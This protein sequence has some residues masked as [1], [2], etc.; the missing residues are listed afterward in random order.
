MM[1]ILS[2]TLAPA[3][4]PF[5][6]GAVSWRAQAD[7]IQCDMS[8]FSG[9]GWFERASH[10]AVCMAES[11]VEQCPQQAVLIAGLGNI[12]FQLQAVPWRPALTGC[13]AVVLGLPCLPWKAGWRFLAQPCRAE[14]WPAVL[15]V[16][17]CFLSGEPV[18]W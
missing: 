12:I 11:E 10:F 17:S 1:L 5:R 13:R 14:D 2:S 4:Q 3:R 9:L 8:E 16:R 7:H 15:C 6:A 18:S